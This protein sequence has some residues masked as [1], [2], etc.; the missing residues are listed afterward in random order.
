MR[1][2]V[3]IAAVLLALASPVMAGQSATPR[4]LKPE[5]PGKVFPL[6]GA[7]S[8]TSCAGYG[9]GFVKV[10]GTD[11]CVHVGGSISIGTGGSR[12]AR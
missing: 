9:P 6:K 5:P 11:T 3:P 4:A 7:A 10:E 12:G 8:H 1:I 2:S